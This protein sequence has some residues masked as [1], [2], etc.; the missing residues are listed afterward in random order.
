MATKTSLGLTRLAPGEPISG[1]NFGIQHA[2]P[3][4][5]DYFIRLLLH[6]RHDDHPAVTD[7]VT[8]PTITVDDVGGTIPADTQISVGYTFLDVDGGETLMTEPITVGTIAGLTTPEALPTLALDATAGVLLANIYSYAVTLTDGNGGETAMSPAATLTIPP[9]SPT[10][11]I[12]V[13]GLTDL[14]ASVPGAVGWR[15]WRSVGGDIIGLL[16][17]GL[18]A[19]D[20]FVDDGTTGVDCNVAPPTTTTNTRATSVLHVTVPAPAPPEATQFRIYGS[21]DGSF[22]DPAVLGTY[23]IADL[24]AAK[25]YT[26]LAFTE[27]A[28]PAV[29]TTQPGIPGGGGGGGLFSYPAN[30]SHDFTVD[31]VSFLGANQAVILTDAVDGPI[32]L[33]YEG[34]GQVSVPFPYTHVANFDSSAVEQLGLDFFAA[35]PAPGMRD[36]ST[37]VRFQFGATDFTGNFS[38]FIG[39]RGGFRTYARLEFDGAGASTLSVGTE[40][41]VEDTYDQAGAFDSSAVVFAAD[42][43]Y[44]LKVTRDGTMLSAALYDADPAVNPAIA[45]IAPVAEASRAYDWATRANAMPGFG[46]RMVDTGTRGDLIRVF[47]MASHAESGGD[48][49]QT[50]HREYVTVADNGSRFAPVK[51]LN[52]VGVNVTDERPSADRITVAVPG[53]RS[54]GLDG[55]G[56]AGTLASYLNQ[57]ITV[58]D[59]EQRIRASAA[60]NDGRLLLAPAPGFYGEQTRGMF[61]GV[62]A[63]DVF[64]VIVK[65]IDIANFL[66]V[67]VNNDTTTPALEIVDVN[68]GVETVIDSVPITQIINTGGVSWWASP[69]P[70]WVKGEVFFGASVYVGAAVYDY[71]PDLDL[72]TPRY[73]FGTNLV[74][75]MHDRWALQGD[76]GLLLHPAAGGANT[77]RATEFLRRT[78]D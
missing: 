46:W 72:A 41:G 39:H 69:D 21:I 58:E 3:E 1:D 27:G 71:H 68:A 17:T 22:G 35:D 65:G 67:R 9:G 4:L 16:A 52:F 48:G 77:L 70:V 40:D 7:P 59:T 44:W 6:H 36:G 63:D 66:A 54:I 24:G 11:R 5:I 20:A 42:T 29:A 53:M 12:T 76:G 18:A 43:D 57:N 60:G 15:L 38:A 49:Y 23:P 30:W 64:G 78:T 62:A 47:A 74:G 73:H 13:S 8:A 33:L 32:A 50:F 37:T 25:D 55:F 19:T 26:E 2:N 45:E 10:N 61:I 34:V 51:E 14:V 28:P 56:W 75:A 31:D